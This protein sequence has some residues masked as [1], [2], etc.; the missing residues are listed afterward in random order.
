MGWEAAVIRW[1]SRA[2]WSVYEHRMTDMLE[3]S[4][5]PQQLSQLTCCAWRFAFCG[6]LISMGGQLHF[7]LWADRRPCWF[8][9]FF[10]SSLS[11]SAESIYLCFLLCILPFLAHFSVSWQ[12]AAWS[13]IG[14][15]SPASAR[16][17]SLATRPWSWIAT[18]RRWAQILM[19]VTDCTL[20]SCHWKGSWTSTKT[21]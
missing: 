21:R 4:V 5:T 9:C 6:W 2:Y 11:W 18:Q 15:L 8:V 14:V 12:A 19:S 7:W 13:L 10:F 20:R 1:K 16:C 17:V 3:R